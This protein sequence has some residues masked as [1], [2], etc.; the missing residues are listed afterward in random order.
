M[1]IASHRA[2][3]RL[4]AA[5]PIVILMLLWALFFWRILT[6]VPADRLTFQQGDFT[7]QFLAY[8]QLAYRQLAAG[9]FPVIEEC[10][11]SGH[12]FQ[13]DPQSQV[14]YPPVLAAMLIGRAL[15]WAEYPLRA[16]EWEVMLHVLLA[17][18]GMYGFL[19][20]AGNEPGRPPLHRV[21]A[22]IGAVAYGFGGFMTGY[23]MLQTAILQTA[24]WLPLV[25]L[26]IRRLATRQRWV[27]A[28]ALLAVL[29]FFAFTAGH[30]QTLLFVAYTGAVA[31]A[32]W[33]WQARR[34]ERRA[35]LLKQGLTRGGVAALLAVGLSAAQL[36][37]TLS[38]MLAST[39]ASLTFDQ[40]GRGF[41]LHDIALVALTG[42]INIWQPIYV[43]I[44]PLALAG[45]AI[46]AAARAPDRRRDAWLWVAA[47]LGALVLSFGANAIGFD[48]AYLLAPGYRQ[49]QAQERHA[50]IVTFA[51]C[52]LAA[53]GADVLLRPM[54][55]RARWKLQR[56]ARWLGLWG[57]IAF[58]GLIGLL[59]AQRLA[60]ESVQA[61]LSTIADKLALIVLGLLGTAALFAWRA[62]LG[63]TP[64]W[65]WGSALL[66]LVVFDLFG[67]NRYTATQPPADPFP[68]NPLIAP[69][70]PTQRPNGYS[71]VY[72][73]FGLPLNGACIAGLNEVGGG[74][75]I[76]LRAYKSLLDN[77]PEDVMVKLLNARHAVT[78]RGAMETPEGVMI[79]WFLLA[80]DTFE[81]KEASTY[82]LDWEP[83]TFNGAWIPRQITAAPSEAAMYD[84]MRTPGFD[85]FA[86][87][88]FI[89][90]LDEWLR[91]GA[92]GSAAIEGKSPGYVKVAVNADAPAL[93]VVSEAYHW[94]W[95]ALLNGQAV[96]PVAVNGA[97]LGVPIP[98]GAFSV[99][100]SYRPL[101]LYAGTAV[102]AIT[103]IVM[104]LMVGRASG[105]QVGKST[106][107]QVSRSGSVES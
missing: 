29:V 36:I 82:R 12:P 86:E 71:R 97:L 57:A 102:S 106:S 24:A 76:V 70:G 4:A 58:S 73:H 19:R 83:Q 79:P 11:Y 40:A 38:F 64:R 48:L 61:T 53:Y 96:R 42:V 32:F 33:L 7:L 63:A 78:W 25:L 39:R 34:G 81:G 87:A 3:R 95:V 51:L 54:R 50:V 99:E 67:A 9:R 49:F 2:R 47:G 30:P 5:A 37:P 105:Q 18:I 46:F 15:G 55:P 80:R 20:V 101:D 44:A 26:A 21:A 85:P 74:S 84:R 75:P 6:P 104:A 8:R 93:L 69:I 13:A 43:G 17:A 22:L 103:A 60:G 16:L 27:P 98:A 56:A 66:G 31:F 90:P 88:I 91:R 68:P 65:L 10:L 94:N 92:N 77:A 14:L 100:F 89:N 52:A 72:N 35:A 1:I 41:A 62:R 28:A 107:R 45:V 59:I 23:A